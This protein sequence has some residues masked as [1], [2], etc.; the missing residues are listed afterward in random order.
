MASTGTALYPGASTFPGASVFPGQGTIPLFRLY[1]SFSD[2]TT[3]EPVWTELSS[4]LRSISWTRGRNSELENFDAG[5][6]TAV[7][8]NRD[9]ALDPSVAPTVTPMNQIMV[10]E[11]FDGSRQ[12]C[13]FA[14]SESWQQSWPGGG[15]FDAVA[16]L[17]GSDH[18][19]ILS[20]ASSPISGTTTL[21][22]SALITILDAIQSKAPRRLDPNGTSRAVPTITYSG[23]SVGILDIINQTVASD[24][25]DL[26]ASLFGINQAFFMARDGSA[27]WLSAAHRL[28]APYISP[29][30]TFGDGGGSELPYLSLDLDDS[31]SFLSNSWTINGTAGSTDISSDAASIARYGLR[32]NTRT[33]LY[34][35]T[36]LSG[37]VASQYVSKYKDPQQRVVSLS[38][39]MADAAT[40]SAVFGLDLLD[41]IRIL[42]TPP[43]GG[44]RID[45]T[46]YIQRIEISATPG[47][48]PTC[49]LGVSPL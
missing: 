37:V 17:S 13:I 23:A 9:R 18:F 29:A 21:I 26:T 38:P 11:E 49:R 14:Y 33:V 36:T 24:F 8:D 44:A 27:V 32:S 43:G 2:Y 6:L 47:V 7:L 46:V 41:P 1:A 12:S 15:N 42:R 20:L 35:L 30:A 3:V 48:P 40:A 31:D 22:K 39:N 34:D 28:A 10:F 45:E 16:T 4:R 25:G 5:T 19:K